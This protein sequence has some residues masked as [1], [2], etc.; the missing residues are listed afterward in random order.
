MIDPGILAGFVPWIAFV[1]ASSFLGTRLA[2]FIGLALTLI[3]F[4]PN[5]LKKTYTS[6]DLFGV[7]FFL[8]LALSSVALSDVDLER[9][10]AWSG[11]LINGSLAFFTWATILRGDPFT[12]AYAR[13]MV[14][15]EH[16]Q[17][18]MF[19]NSTKS[20][21]LGWSTAFLG[22]TV[23]FLAGAL[24]GFN[25]SLIY[26]LGIGCMIPAIFWHQR[27]YAAA[28]AEGERLREAAQKNRAPQQP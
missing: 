10:R 20:I 17:S 24:M 26:V 11:V 14:P 18:S 16:W 3:L 27:V 9:L 19:L 1:V 23:I 12:R 5:V 28:Q 2:A 8:L 25:G 7:I 13:R 22:A 4:L 21:A 15:R 6:M